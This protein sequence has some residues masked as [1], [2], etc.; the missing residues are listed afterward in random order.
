MISVFQNFSVPQISKS[1]LAVL[2]YNSLSARWSTTSG[3]KLASWETSLSPSPTSRWPH[4]FAWKNLDWVRFYLCKTA[5]IRAERCVE[6][7]CIFRDF[8]PGHQNVLVP[9]HQEGGAA[10]SPGKSSGHRGWFNS[11]F[12]PC[13][14]CVIIDYFSLILFLIPH[15]LLVVIHTSSQSRLR[16]W[17]FFC[18]IKNRPTSPW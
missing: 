13:L 2:T 16:P 1:V 12:I 18:D 17:F 8:F 15:L 11:P 9:A 3:G 5:Q 10:S 14:W 4:I 7:L 6:F